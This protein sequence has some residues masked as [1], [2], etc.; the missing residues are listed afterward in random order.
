MYAM[1]EK[2]AVFR[3]FCFIKAAKT[4]QDRKEGEG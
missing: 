3:R 4:A 1:S 2:T